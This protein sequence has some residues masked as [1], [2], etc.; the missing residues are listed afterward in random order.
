MVPP[1]APLLLVPSAEASGKPGTTWICHLTKTVH[2]RSL[3]LRKTSRKRLDGFDRPISTCLELTPHIG[4][5]VGTGLPCHYTR[6]PREEIMT[7]TNFAYAFEEMRKQG[8]LA[9][10]NFQC[11]VDYSGPA[12]VTEA[13]KLVEQGVEVKGCCFYTQQDNKVKRKGL[14]FFLSYGCLLDENCGE[15]GLATDVVGR[16]VVRCLAK[17]GVGYAWDGDPESRILVRAKSIRK[18]TPKEAMACE[19]S[20]FAEF[21]MEQM[22]HPYWASFS[23]N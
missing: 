3:T 15:M 1:P 18:M 8:I 22:E 13:A 2:L 7:K 16:L 20:P 17:Y 12:I 6:C 11:C 9:K 4:S 5:C 23:L 19:M 10:H 21:E 14:D